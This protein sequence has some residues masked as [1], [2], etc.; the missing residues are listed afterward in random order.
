MTLPDAHG[1]RRAVSTRALSA[2]EVCQASLESISSLNPSLNAFITLAA[3]RALERAAR[4][5]ASADRP[6]LPL[7]GVPIAVKDNICTRGIRTTAGSRVL[8]GYDPPYDAAVIERLEDAGAIVVGKTNCDEFAM[9][10]S[11]EHSAFGP[12]RNPWA[13]DRTPGGSS[14]GSAV[15]VAAR[16]T[17]LALGSETGG[18]VR[19]PAALCGVSGLK[20]TY[21][22]I[23]R[24][25]L[26]AFSSSMDQVG[27]FAANI[28]DLALLLQVMAGPDARD[29]TCLT[30]APPDYAA[31]LGDG[32]TGLRV[33]VP[34]DV[35]SDGVDPG[36]RNAFD[37]SLEVLRA[38]GASVVDVDLPHARYATPTYAIVA[39]AEAS[40][41][42][43]RYDGVRFGPRG[44]AGTLNGMYLRTRALFGR[45]VK[46]RLMLGTYV[47]SGGYYEAYYVR[48]QRVR[49]LL[50]Q[51]YNRAFEVVDVI[52]TPT[53]PTTAF[54]LGARIEDPL[55]MY[56]ADI[57]TVSANLS[58][59]PA[60]SVPCGFADG[61]PVG[62]QLTGRAWDEAGL[63]RIGAEY[64]RRTAW[65]LR[66]PPT[67]V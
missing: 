50:R 64:E 23:S 24:Y 33:G 38:A 9:G 37:A 49:T 27:P 42:L 7:L 19:Q 55:Q 56:L 5:D 15:A 63:L 39:M 3:D 40:S 57:F 61:L 32:I 46:R 60:L 21:G 54:P 28:A 52:A 48:A 16:M 10:S 17:P 29:S 51:D 62:L 66:L 41:N 67:A 58:G 13:T 45:E 53:S 26:I 65:H 44:E 14:G 2:V 36:V 18:S 47:L 4:L 34:R 11:T 31:T 1:I 20:P 22:R 6:S 43:G 59:L 35:L 12:S 8:E 25:G 30:E